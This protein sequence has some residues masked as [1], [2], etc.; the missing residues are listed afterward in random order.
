MLQIFMLNVT[1]TNQNFENWSIFDKVIINPQG[2][3]FVETQ[4]T[5]ITVFTWNFW[6]AWPSASIV[7]MSRWLVG[8][9]RTKKFGLHTDTTVTLNTAASKEVLIHLVNV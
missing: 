1:I 3:Y 5:Y 6:R 9:S 4:C 8:S 7:S 2:V